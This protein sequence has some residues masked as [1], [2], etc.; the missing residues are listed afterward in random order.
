MSLGREDEQTKD[1][2]KEKEQSLAQ[3]TTFSTGKLPFL[4]QTANHS[5]TKSSMLIPLKKP[6]RRNKVASQGDSLPEEVSEP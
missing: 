4:I 3:S 5:K 2:L 1:E 6:K